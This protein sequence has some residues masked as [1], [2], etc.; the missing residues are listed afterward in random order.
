MNVA[1]DANIWISFSIGKQLAVLQAILL[2]DAHRQT[3][4]IHE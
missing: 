2:D 4:Q 1:F 3:I